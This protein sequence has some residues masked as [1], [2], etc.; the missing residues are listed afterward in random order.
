MTEV[1]RAIDAG[2]IRA[3]YV[4][5]ENPVLSEADA[6]H[7]EQS[8][9]R[10]EFLVVQDIFLTETARLADVVL[11]AATFA[12]KDGTF[13]NTERRV[14]RVRKVLEPIGNSRAD[15]WIIGQI[16]QRLGAEGFL[17]SHP[18]EI[19]A[20]I[21]TL[22]PSYGGISYPRLENGGVQWPCPDL[23]HPGT[24]ILHTERFATQDGKARFVPLQYKPPA[25]LPDDEFPLVLTTDRSLFHYH[26]GTMTRRT[27]GLE[28]LDGCELLRIHP[29][30]SSRLGVSDG[31]IV[32]LRSRRGAVTVRVQVTDICL[33]GM[34]SLTFHF[35]ETPTNVLTHAALDPVAKIP[36]TKVCAVRIERI[37]T[38][39]GGDGARK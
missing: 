38:L 16:A 21:A 14:Q 4:M 22:T 34:V 9:R 5:G 26:T 29:A 6:H 19:M 37:E 17:F 20:E 39:V 2:T 18:A 1:P 8:L 32:R 10:L 13:T 31:Q 11:P 23:G 33:P 15:W 3:V 35:A 24:P 7:V 12:E 28:K 25:E 27:G 30:D 36:E